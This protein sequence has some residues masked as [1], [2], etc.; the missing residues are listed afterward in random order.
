MLHSF[1]ILQQAQGIRHPGHLLQNR[2]H[3][4][5]SLVRMVRLRHNYQ[6]LHH[7]TKLWNAKICSESSAVSQPRHDHKD[8]IYADP[9][10][11]RSKEAHRSRHQFRLASKISLR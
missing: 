1:E 3:C 2:E 8:G 5:S 7:E 10:E 9:D 4:R 6:N 11:R